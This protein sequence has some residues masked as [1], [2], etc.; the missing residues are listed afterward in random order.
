M[1]FQM[2]TRRPLN[3]CSGTRVHPEVHLRCIHTLAAGGGPAEAAAASACDAAASGDLGEA[4]D[5]AGQR[6]TALADPTSSVRNAVSS[7]PA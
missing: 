2:N 6:S 1:D 5:N 3:C 4:G 7:R